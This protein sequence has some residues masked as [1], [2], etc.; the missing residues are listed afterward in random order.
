MWRKVWHRAN[1]FSFRQTNEVMQT[2]HTNQIISFR[3]LW[4]R[5]DI[6][7]RHECL[8][9]FVIITILRA[10]DL[11]TKV[12]I[13]HKWTKIAS[14]LKTSFGDYF[15]F[16]SVMSGLC[17]E[18]IS[19]IKYLWREFQLLFTEDAYDFE[20]KL[21]VQFLNLLKANEPLAANV[22]FPFVIQLCHLIECDYML[23]AK[24]LPILMESDLKVFP[25]WFNNLIFDISYWKD[26]I[27]TEKEYHNKIGLKDFSLD[28]V[29][30]HILLSTTVI[31]NLNCFE[32]NAKEI[33]NGFFFKDNSLD[34]LLKTSF[35]LRFLFNK[36]LEVTKVDHEEFQ[37]LEEFLNTFS[38]YDNLWDKQP[39]YIFNVWNTICVQVYL[40]YQAKLNIQGTIMK[41]VSVYY[42]ANEWMS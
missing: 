36:N 12:A 23:N 27:E 8:K 32:T 35:H 26:T 18:K 37:K 10:T 22:T 13:L 24:L 15:G 9:Y 20:T 5:K 41:E 17:H 2:K 29:I 19:S 33:S 14:K 42:W 11:D 30:Q 38:I 4:S 39:D 16:G 21:K 3:H 25:N 31:D 6:I 1:D 34:E 7:I 40:H 28:D